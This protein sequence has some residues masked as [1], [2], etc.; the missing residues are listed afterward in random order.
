MEGEKK[1]KKNI[2]VVTGNGDNLDIS[3]VSRYVQATKP[4]IKETNKKI[5][6]PEKKKKK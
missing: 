1:E 5:V 2:E 4:K 6:I 3:C